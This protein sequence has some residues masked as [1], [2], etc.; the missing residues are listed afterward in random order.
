MPEI[1]S[2]P[3]FISAD[4]KGIP[5]RT[6]IPPP[7]LD[8]V[9]RPVNSAEEIEEDIMGNLKTLWHG[10]PDEDIIKALL[11]PESVNP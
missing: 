2:H 3:F 1:L 7:S 4:P 6:L 10:A 11:S 5:G 8:E 9:E